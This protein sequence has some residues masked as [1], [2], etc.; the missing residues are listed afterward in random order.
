MSE[1]TQDIAPSVIALARK[2]DVTVTDP[3]NIGN[4]HSESPVTVG[5]VRKLKSGGY[6]LVVKRDGRRPAWMGGPPR[7]H[8]LAVPCGPPLAAR[9][10]AR[11]REIERLV[12][13]SPQAQDPRL[14]TWDRGEMVQCWGSWRMSG[15]EALWADTTGRLVYETGHYDDGP[16]VWLLTEKTLAAEAISLRVEKK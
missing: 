10:D 16:S 7:Y 4:Y 8:Y 11:R 3:A 14:Q 12:Q 9:Q 13:Q 2:S 15:H 6:C 1:P 5:Q